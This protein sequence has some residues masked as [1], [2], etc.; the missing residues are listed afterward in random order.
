MSIL[1]KKN[2]ATFLSLFFLARSIKR[3]KGK[4]KADFPLQDFF[5]YL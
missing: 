4:E 1:R 2:N 5:N 3:R